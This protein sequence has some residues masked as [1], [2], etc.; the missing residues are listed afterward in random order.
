MPSRSW[1]LFVGFMLTRFHLHLS[2]G[3]SRQKLIP[4][5]TRAIRRQPYWGLATI[6]GNLH[7]IAPNKLQGRVGR[8]LFHIL[9]GQL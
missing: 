2:P 8:S 4:H 5:P 3:A 1:D 9:L 6:L 7:I